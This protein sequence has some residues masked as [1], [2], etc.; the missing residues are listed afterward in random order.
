M[1][2]WP[3]KSLATRFKKRPNN[4]NLIKTCNRCRIGPIKTMENQEPWE[5]IK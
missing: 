2:G 3:C 1:Q 4:K 5:V